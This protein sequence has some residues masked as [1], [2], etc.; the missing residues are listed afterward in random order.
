MEIR[1]VGKSE[2]GKTV[3]LEDLKAITSCQFTVPISVRAVVISFNKFSI[4]LFTSDILNCFH[5]II[6]LTL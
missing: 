6:I 4:I 2:G 1:K 5:H 3:D